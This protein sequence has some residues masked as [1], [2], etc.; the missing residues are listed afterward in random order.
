MATALQNVQDIHTS[1]VTQYKRLLEQTQASSAQQLLALQ[2]ALDG[3]KARAKEHGFLFNKL[4]IMFDLYLKARPTVDFGQFGFDIVSAMRGDGFGGFDEQGIRAVTSAMRQAD[5]MR[6]LHI[7]LDASMPGDIPL[8]ISLLNKYA[9]TCY[10]ILGHLPSEIVVKV[11]PYL[12]LKELL[13]CEL[14]SHAWLKICRNDALYRVLV[15]Q[16]TR[17]DPWPPKEP[18]EPVEGYWRSMYKALR[19][20]ELNWSWGNVQSLRFLKGHTGFCTTL[21]LK[22]NILLSGS[23]DETIRLWDIDTGEQL[24]C[25]QVKAVSCVDYLED[26][27][28]FAVGFH[29]V[30]RVQIFSSLTWSPLQTL[31]GHLYGIRAVTI[32]PTY[33]V[34]AGADKAIVAWEWRTGKKIVRF[35]QQINMCIGVQIME[36]DR[37]VSVT[38]GKII[39]HE[40]FVRT[41]SI[42]KREMLGQFQLN[43]LACPDA[44][45]TRHLT[46]V[47]VGPNNMLQWFAAKGRQMTCATKNVILHLTWPNLE[48]AVSS[49]R[50]PP[51]GIPTPSSSL[52][53]P[54]ARQRIVSAKPANGKAGLSISTS[55]LPP[56]TPSKLD[57]PPASAASPPVRKPS[58]PIMP[59]PRASLRSDV[60]A[61]P[62][63]A[64]PSQKVGIVPILDHVLI[65]PDVACGAV[66]PRKRRV[67]TSTR[68]SSRLGADRRIFVS[69]YDEIAAAR[70]ASA[71]LI[72]VESPMES[73]EPPGP[74]FNSEAKGISEIRGAWSALAR[75]QDGLDAVSLPKA[76][77]GLA[78]PELNPM[79]LALNHEKI[80]VGC[81]DGTIYVMSFVGNEY[82]IAE[83]RENALANHIF[84]ATV[85]SN[86]AS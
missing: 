82:T 61:S 62:L 27:E 84:S 68:F 53:P 60:P 76:F 42:N 8:M 32:S 28:V 3:E 37:I 52:S 49:S 66:D 77:N 41:F 40:S 44:L 30:G 67:V 63:S 34:S 47:G 39:L 4:K 55:G 5:R 58:R 36:E 65:T 33:M 43:Q 25:L 57:T 86:V 50:L 6:L 23:Y 73:P 14:V 9:L 56:N 74:T 11:L 2:A 10:D 15:N 81:A 59:S 78:T 24:K 12:S 64:S 48:T 20:R 38:I 29:D 13:S 54:A 16:V 18:V 35:G 75:G 79:A 7:I 69:T 71:S 26:H 83:A 72:P 1:K 31:Q 85:E 17:H 51:N 46:S 45:L 19:N 80:V 21:N 70:L 22:G